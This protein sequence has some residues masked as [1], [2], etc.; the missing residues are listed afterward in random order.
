LAEPPSPLDPLV[1]LGRIAAPFGVQGWVKIQPYTA[2]P[3]GLEGYPI[4]WVGAKE[5]YKQYEVEQVAVHGRS[6]L[7]KLQG[8][9]GR[10][11][12][13]LLKGCEV[14][15]LRHEL[16]QNGPGEFYWSDLVGAAVVN[17]EGTVLGTI[18]EMTDNG[19]QSV[20]V[21]SGER[22]RLIPFVAPI[23]T[24]VSLEKR[25]VIVQWGADF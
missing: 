9:S 8:I 16:P 20:M 5:P 19:A 1:L 22:E 7:C 24:E 23:V 2:K 4:Y 21:V 18:A 17:T 14:G 15:V 6:V 3:S 11:K 25:Q 13:A 10:E 12:A